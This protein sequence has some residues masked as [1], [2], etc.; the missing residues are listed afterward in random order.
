MATTRLGGKE[1]W[2]PAAGSF[3]QTPQPFSEEALAP[4]ANTLARR[5]QAR[6]D[7]I[8][9]ETLGRVQHDFGANDISIL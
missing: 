7:G 9:V 1:R 5:V 8:V 2:A 4:L 3:L 6:G